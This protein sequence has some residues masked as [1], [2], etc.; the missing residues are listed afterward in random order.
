M[1][2]ISF[3]GM[4]PEQKAHKKSERATNSVIRSMLV[5]ARRGKP[6]S[7]AQKAEIVGAIEAAC[8]DLKETL[9]APKGQKKPKFT[10]GAADAVATTEPAATNVILRKAG[11]K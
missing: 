7:D 11:A 1:A 10:L 3:K 2:K 9:A 6:L 4:T 5:I 8:K